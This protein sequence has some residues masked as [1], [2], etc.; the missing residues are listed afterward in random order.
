[1]N[2]YN[3]FTCD[4]VI[5]P[6]KNGKHKATGSVT[7]FGRGS[8][9]LPIQFEEVSG[10]FFNKG[11]HL[12]SLKG[13]PLLSNSINSPFCFFRKI[14]LTDLSANFMKFS[15]S[16]M[17]EEVIFPKSALYNFI[18]VN[19]PKMTKVD[20]SI[21]YIDCIN[22]KMTPIENIKIKETGNIKTIIMDFHE[23]FNWLELVYV[24]ERVSIDHPIS[25]ILIEHIGKVS[26]A[27]IIKFQADLANGGF[28][29][30]WIE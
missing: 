20:L 21:S 4:G 18:L 9:E 16:P 10:H 12:T 1:M 15:S 23:N 13:F 19:C 5:I 7:Y 28:N 27:N 17:L 24:S 6:L 26:K 30:N 29:Y 11:T 14:D 2:A 25:D 3:M 22:I 8:K